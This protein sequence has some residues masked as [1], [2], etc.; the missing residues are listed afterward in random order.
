MV[1]VPGP[2]PGGTL[3][4]DLPD[5][6]P[7]SVIQH[8]GRNNTPEN[9]CNEHTITAGYPNEC[10]FVWFYILVDETV[11]GEYPLL[12]AFLNLLQPSAR[13]PAAR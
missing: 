5:P 9:N 10:L 4:T 12:I 11:S 1:P 3:I 2:G 6:S 7:D 13:S 8:T